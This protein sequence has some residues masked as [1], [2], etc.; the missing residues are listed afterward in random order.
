M[1]VEGWKKA[2][3]PPTDL[4]IQNKFS[5]LAAGEDKQNLPGNLSELTEPK[6]FVYT[7]GKRQVIVTGDSLLWG[8]RHQS[9]GLT[10]AGIS[11]LLLGVVG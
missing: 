8:P 4:Q 7:E 3:V 2:L 5:A 9:G 11:G 6:S 1:G 10:Q